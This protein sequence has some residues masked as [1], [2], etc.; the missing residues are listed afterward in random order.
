MCVCERERGVIR[1]NIHGGNVNRTRK[2]E[3]NQFEKEPKKLEKIQT[4]YIFMF[5]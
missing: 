3:K 5:K 1:C 2:G 4:T